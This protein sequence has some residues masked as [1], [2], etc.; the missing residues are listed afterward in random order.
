MKYIIILLA[1]CACSA[2]MITITP[3]CINATST[4]LLYCPEASVT[5]VVDGNRTVDMVG[6]ESGVGETIQG[7]V[8]GLR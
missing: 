7:I 1:L 3:D 5:R 8:E 6:S 4:T 2:R